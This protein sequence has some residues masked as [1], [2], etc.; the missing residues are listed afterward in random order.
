MRVGLRAML[1]QP[2]FIGALT[3]ALFHQLIQKGLNI[4]LPLIDSYLDPLLFLPILLHLILFERR[5]LFGKGPTY[6]FS[7]AQILLIVA[8]IAVLCEYYFPRWNDAFTAD[9]LDAIF[10]LI[11]GVFF[12]VFCNKPLKA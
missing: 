11:G 2:W 9:Y 6:V 4:N 1:L 12:G 5:Y 8:L 3:L 10:Y 7:W